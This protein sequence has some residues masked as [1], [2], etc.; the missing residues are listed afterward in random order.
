MQKLLQ[1]L[2]YVC[3]FDGC[4]YGLRTGPI[5]GHPKG[6]P[7]LKQRGVQTR[8]APVRRVL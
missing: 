2:P 6:L 5:P 4:A 3:C 1:L 7:M 8:H